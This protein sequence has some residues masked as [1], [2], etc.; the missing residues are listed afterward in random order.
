MPSRKKPFKGPTPEGVFQ[1]VDVG[2]GGAE[3]IRQRAV[4]SKGR[5]YVV[6]EP[7]LAGEKLRWLKDNLEHCG[8][9]VKPVKISGFIDE[10]ESHGLRAR[11]INID[12]PDTGGVEKKDV[13]DFGKLFSHAR[14]I[15]VPGGKIF[16]S[17]ENK[18]FLERLTAQAKN[19]GFASS[20]MPVLN[21]PRAMRTEYMQSR[22][23][24][25]GVVYRVVMQI[26]KP[27]VRNN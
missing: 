5:K 9:I 11:H 8:V 23:H 20:F 15:L 22:D 14:N 21:N 3:W 7:H 12:M 18:S 4:K 19:H 25:G 1:T 16:I 10:M 2:S 24:A 26:R 6:V 27:D 17:S 13:Y